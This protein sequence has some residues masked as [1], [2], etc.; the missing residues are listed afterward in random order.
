VLDARRVAASEPLRSHVEE[1]EQA[2]LDRGNTTAHAKTTATRALRVLRCAGAT[3]WSEID[4]RAIERFL[5]AERERGLSIQSSNHLLTATRG[6]CRWM[7]ERS[8]A[9]EDP[10]RASGS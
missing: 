4:G 1:F 6:F 5:G 10:T 7:V 9:S 3:Y 8:L 2:L